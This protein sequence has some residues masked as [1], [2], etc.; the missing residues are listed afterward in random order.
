MSDVG[1]LGIE[2]GDERENWDVRAEIAARQATLHYHGV[3]KF[4]PDKWHRVC[5]QSVEIEYG[6]DPV[7]GELRFAVT[8][9][10]AGDE[11]VR[12]P[13]VLNQEEAS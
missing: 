6:K 5:A 3:I 2:E 11:R 8:P 1:I 12:M 13:L 9:A 4:P 10:A 7:T